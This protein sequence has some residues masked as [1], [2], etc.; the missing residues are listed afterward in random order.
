MLLKHRLI[1]F[2]DCLRV[3]L[4]NSASLSNITTGKQTLVTVSL[5][6]PVIISRVFNPII[7]AV[8]AAVRSDRVT[9]S[10]TA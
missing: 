10:T 3:V 7:L 2:H 5:M 8:S 4:L 6:F 1:Q 9:G